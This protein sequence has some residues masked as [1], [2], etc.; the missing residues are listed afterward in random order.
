MPMTKLVGD[1][2]KAL[3]DRPELVEVTEAAGERGAQLVELSVDEGDLGRVIGKQ[4]R[5][6]RSIRTVL[7]A[8][9]MKQNARFQL[10]ILE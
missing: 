5:T 4:G 8:A 2:A 1:I 10:E 7:G 6:A 3:V 9:A